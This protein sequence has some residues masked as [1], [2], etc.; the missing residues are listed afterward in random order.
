MTK[1]MGDVMQKDEMMAV[2][3]RRDKLVKHF[4]DR[5]ATRGEAAV[6]FKM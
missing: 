6:L 5:I 2:L 3:A 4:E 1:S